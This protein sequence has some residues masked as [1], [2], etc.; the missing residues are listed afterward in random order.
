MDLLKSK[1]LENVV[2]SHKVYNY[3][4]RLTESA[5]VAEI[6]GKQALTGKD[7]NAWKEAMT[8]EVN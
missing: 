1:E 4:A 5:F 7:S 6:P 8:S 2:G 3:E